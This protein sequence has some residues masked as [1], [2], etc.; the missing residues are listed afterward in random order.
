MKFNEL[1]YCI[2]SHEVEL[3][4]VKYFFDNKL[5]TVFSSKSYNNKTKPSFLILNSQGKILHKE[6]KLK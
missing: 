1:E 4:G 6:I 5:I 3:K 2:R